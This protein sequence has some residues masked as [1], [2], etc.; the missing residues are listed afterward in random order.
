MPPTD[1]AKEFQNAGRER[2]YP[3]I[4]NPNWLVLRKRRELFR[5]WLEGSFPKDAAVLDI[6]GRIQPYRTLLP[7][8]RYVAVD[9][10]LTPLVNVIANAERIPFPSQEFDLVLCTQMLEYAPDPGLVLSEIHRVLKPGGRLLLSVPSIFPQEAEEDRWRFL[11]AG[12]RQLLSAF[13]EVEIVPEGGSI[14]GFFRTINVCLHLFAKYAVIRTA[15]SYTVIPVLN[16]AGLG[17]EKMVRSRNHAFA[18]NYSAIA[19][20]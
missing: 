2:L 15:L 6:G 12:I 5:H 11:P 13:S 7:G 14:A 1:A 16:L 9:L 17:L 3:A 8:T 20:K 18:V 10:R 4:T 19:R